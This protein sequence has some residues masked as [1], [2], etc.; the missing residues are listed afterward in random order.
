MS[1]NLSL[2]PM[3]FFSPLKGVYCTTELLT[4]NLLIFMLYIMD[5]AFIFY[6]FYNIIYCSD[7]FVDKHIP[8]C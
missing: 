1:D 7:Y 2:I 4:Y 6:V 5:R 3:H 8:C